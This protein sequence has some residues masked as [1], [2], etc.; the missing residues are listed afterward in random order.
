MDNV[1]V[2][3]LLLLRCGELVALVLGADARTGAVA[4]VGLPATEREA[5]RV[6]GEAKGWIRGVVVVEDEVTD[7][8]AGRVGEEAAG[9]MRGV[10]VAEVEAT[11]L[12]AERVAGRDTDGAGAG[13]GA[14]ETGARVTDRDAG[15]VAVGEALA[16]GEAVLAGLTALAVV[17]GRVVTER[18]AGREVVAGAALLVVGRGEAD[19]RDVLAVRGVV[20]FNGATM[21]RRDSIGMRDGISLPAWTGGI[22]TAG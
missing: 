22:A 15:L 8:E 14:M 11:D 17:V 2:A 12:L 5:G 18:E 6:G 3:A 9:W 7:R 10:A 19:I 1:T 21:G 4:V 20:P 16:A 13:V